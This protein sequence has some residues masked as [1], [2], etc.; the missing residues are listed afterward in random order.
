MLGRLASPKT[1]R[2]RCRV[3]RLLWH[4]RV[5]GLAFLTCD[6]A[7][8]SLLFRHILPSS[9]SAYS[10]LYVVHSLI[11]THVLF[12]A[13]MIAA[14]STCPRFCRLTRFDL[15]F[16]TSACWHNHLLCFAVMHIV[17]AI[18]EFNFSG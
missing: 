2:L 11:G 5:C 18:C 13:Q 16:P 4:C 17:V 1:S 12:C 15:S 14:L 3:R 9:P 10:V 6:S 8:D 7:Y